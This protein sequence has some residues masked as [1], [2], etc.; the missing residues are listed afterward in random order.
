MKAGPSMTFPFSFSITCDDGSRE[1]YLCPDATLRDRVSH[2]IETGEH[3][4]LMLKGDPLHVAGEWRFYVTRLATAEEAEHATDRR[5]E[6]E[7][8]RE[9]IRAAVAS[10][11]A[12]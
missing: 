9:R 12:K 4:C 10:R 7:Q 8:L 6:V 1:V 3:L 11:S 5:A 2:A